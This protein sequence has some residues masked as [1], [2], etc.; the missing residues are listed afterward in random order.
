MDVDVAQIG[1][2]EEVNTF[3]TNQKPKGSL[4]EEEKQALRTLKLCFYC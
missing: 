1:G 2:T 3:S 4:T